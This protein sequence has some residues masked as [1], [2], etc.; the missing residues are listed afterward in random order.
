MTLAVAGALALE[1]FV[2]AAA[3]VVL[4]AFAEFLES[5]CT[6][7]ARDAV[8]AVLSLKPETALLASGAWPPCYLSP[9]T[10]ASN[11]GA[12]P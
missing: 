11:G 7:S 3:V 4:F 12:C 8:A 10:L 9:G 2:E 6:A 5:R 1:D